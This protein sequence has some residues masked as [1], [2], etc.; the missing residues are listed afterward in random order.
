MGIKDEPRTSEVRRS[1]DENQQ[2]TMIEP[3]TERERETLRL[4]ATD[5][6]GPEIARRLTLSLHTVRTHTKNIFAK[7]G[8]NNRREAIRR[9]EKLGLL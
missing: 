3:L 6:S 1:V 2:S 5:L 4:L 7:L 8:V 9:A